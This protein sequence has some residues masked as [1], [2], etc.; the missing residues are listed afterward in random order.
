MTVTNSDMSKSLS[1]VVTKFDT[2]NLDGTGVT[3]SGKVRKQKRVGNDGSTWAHLSINSFPQ[4]AKDFIS[5]Y[6]AGYRAI[7]AAEP[8]DPAKLGTSTFNQV[9]QVSI[10]T[11]IVSS[12]Y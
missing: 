9:V 7:V 3:S 12:H 11:T 8:I 4:W 2:K 5:G 1:R 6:K 10:T